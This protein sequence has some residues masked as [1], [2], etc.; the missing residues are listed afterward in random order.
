[1]EGSVIGEKYMNL[2]GQEA[3]DYMLKL[4]RYC[5]KYNGCFTLLWHNSFFENEKMWEMYGEIVRY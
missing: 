3:L 5:R 4:K 2:N 1:M